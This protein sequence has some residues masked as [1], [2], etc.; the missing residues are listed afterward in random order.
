MRFSLWLFA[1]SRLVRDFC[2]PRRAKN[3]NGYSDGVRDARP[4]VSIRDI[5]RNVCNEGREVNGA[6]PS[7]ETRRGNI[8]ILRSSGH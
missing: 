7:R 1:L 8:L 6:V 3:K 2:A 5:R 4:R